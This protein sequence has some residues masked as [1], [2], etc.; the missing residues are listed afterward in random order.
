MK[1]QAESY[2][3]FFNNIDIVLS[4]LSRWNPVMI[5]ELKDICSNDNTEGVIIKDTKTSRRRYLSKKVSK[6]YTN[7][8]TSP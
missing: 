3:R 1:G 4:C 6:T 8:W 2:E 7:Y 5:L